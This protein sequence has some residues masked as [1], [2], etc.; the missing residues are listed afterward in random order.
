MD[1]PP[2]TAPGSTDGKDQRC[3]RGLSIAWPPALR[4]T[5]RRPCAA[6][7]L[8]LGQDVY[9]AISDGKDGHRSVT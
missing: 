4:T 6:S 3:D 5:Y 8:S 7:P 1:I 9:A 2:H